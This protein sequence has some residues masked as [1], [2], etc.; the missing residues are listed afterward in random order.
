MS[1]ENPVHRHESIEGCVR[2]L[3]E[4]QLDIPVSPSLAKTSAF[5]FR[6][7]TGRAALSVTGPDF[8]VTFARLRQESH[9]PRRSGTRLRNDAGKILHIVCH[10]NPNPTLPNDATQA[11]YQALDSVIDPEL[12][13]GIVSLGLVYDVKCQDES[14]QV[15]MT[16]T[17]PTCPLGEELREQ[18][19]A[20]VARLPFVKQAQVDLV[21]DPLWTPDRMQ[22]AA[23]RALGWE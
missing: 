7:R 12:G 18:A 6:F 4:L 14:V 20:A 3:P 22:P 10:M 17:T 19:E 11:V 15:A 21:W 9:H 2:S 1:Q 16:M 23:R 13:I 8:V 5:S